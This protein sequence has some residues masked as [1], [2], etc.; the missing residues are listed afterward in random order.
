MQPNQMLLPRT[1]KYFSE[2]FLQCLKSSLNCEHFQAKYD[3]HS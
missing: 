2:Y 1:Q 3:P